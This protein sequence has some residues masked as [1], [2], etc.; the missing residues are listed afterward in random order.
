MLKLLS[1][2]AAIGLALGILPDHS[3]AV[4]PELIPC[5]GYSYPGVC[6]KAY[7]GYYWHETEDE[8]CVESVEP[9]PLGCHYWL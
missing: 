5:E 1:L 4:E 6:W 2:A 9:Q 3:P 7:G 8:L